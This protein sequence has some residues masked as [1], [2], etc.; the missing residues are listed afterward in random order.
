MALEHHPMLACLCSHRRHGERDAH[1]AIHIFTTLQALRNS[2]KPPAAHGASTGN[3]PKVWRFC[4][5]EQRVRLAGLVRIAL[6]LQPTAAR[7]AAATGSLGALRDAVAHGRRVLAPL[8]CPGVGLASRVLGLVH[9]LELLSIPLR[10]GATTSDKRV[11]PALRRDRWVPVV[12]S[13]G[14]RPVVHDAEDV[15]GLARVDRAGLLEPLPGFR[16][17]VVKVH[18]D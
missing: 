2:S 12:N 14:I 4:P 5:I 15:V 6:D 16:L 1:A 3:P 7:A 9:S 10:Q 8:T 17:D 11:A 13:K 18:G